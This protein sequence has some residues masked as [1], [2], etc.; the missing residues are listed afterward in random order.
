MQTLPS[1]SCPAIHASPARTFRVSVPLFLVSV[2]PRADSH[3][4]YRDAG[5]WHRQ[6]F[7]RYWRWKSRAPGGR[8]P[9]GAELRALIRHMS[10][11]NPIWGAPRIHGELL[12]LG[13]AVAQSTV[14]KYMARKRND[15][16]SGQRLN[17]EQTIAPVKLDRPFTLRRRTMSCCRSAAFSASS[18]LLDLK[19]APTGS[20][21]RGGARPSTPA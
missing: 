13:F 15:D 18:P 9:I 8:P 12:K 5:R 1:S 14:G 6:G 20:G 2:D 10:L 11:D 19:S 17:E 4:P 7:R 21:L 3:R 16:P